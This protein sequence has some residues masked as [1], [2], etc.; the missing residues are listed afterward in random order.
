MPLPVPLLPLV[1]CS[2]ETLAVAVHEQRLTLAVTLMV[3]LPLTRVPAA[4]KVAVLLS[5]V[6]VHA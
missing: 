4:L 1:I 5:S 6:L 3:V 2:H